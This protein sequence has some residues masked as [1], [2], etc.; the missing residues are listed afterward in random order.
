M[1]PTRP[2]DGFIISVNGTVAAMVAVQCKLNPHFQRC[3]DDVIERIRFTGHR[4][5][6]EE[7][8]LGLGGRLFVSQAMPSAH[9]PRLVLGYCIKGDYLRIRVLH[10]V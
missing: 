3:W 1:R 5:G 10:V 8:R 2:S 6:T 9:R 4:E 7:P